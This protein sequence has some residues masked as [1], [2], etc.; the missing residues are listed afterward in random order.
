MLLTIIKVKKA[1]LPPTMKVMKVET[2]SLLATKKLMMTTSQNR[3]LVF[4]LLFLGQRKMRRQ[5]HLTRPSFQY[6]SF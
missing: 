6:T 1:R 3:H 4:L 5:A 2:P